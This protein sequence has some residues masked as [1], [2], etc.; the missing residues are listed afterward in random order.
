MLLDGRRGFHNIESTASI[1]YR[2]CKQRALVSSV[3][4]QKKSTL[5][6][7]CANG[8]T[9]NSERVNNNVRIIGTNCRQRWKL[10]MLHPAA[11]SFNHQ[12]QLLVSLRLEEVY[13]SHILLTATI[14][15]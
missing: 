6:F 4:C 7:D 12:L 10:F 13:L 14:N 11:K 9:W 1:Y 2:F 5:G 15:H 8:K 3:K